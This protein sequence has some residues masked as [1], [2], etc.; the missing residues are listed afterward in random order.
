MLSSFLAKVVIPCQ[1]RPV[2]VVLLYIV[3]FVCSDYIATH[4]KYTIN[5]STEDSRTVLVLE[6]STSS[7][8]AVETC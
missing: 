7:L 4:A 1:G 6:V 2:G 8:P 3:P 5:F